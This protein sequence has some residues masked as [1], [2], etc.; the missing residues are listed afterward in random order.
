[1]AYIQQEGYGDYIAQHKRTLDILSE[2]QQIEIKHSSW[3]KRQRPKVFRRQAANKILEGG[4]VIDRFVP[5]HA[6][7]MLTVTLPGSTFKAFAAV[8]DWSG[9]IMNRV[10]QVIRRVPKDLPPVYWFFVLE[11]QKR[12]ALHMH[13]CIGW[14]VNA[15]MRRELGVA[16]KDKWF[17]CL[18]ELEKKAGVDCFQ[19]LGFAKSWRNSPE[20]WKWDYQQIKKSVASYFAKYC[21]K[22]SEINGEK[23]EAANKRK[24]YHSLSNKG[25]GAKRGIYY[26][27]RYWG[28]S[29]NI[30]TWIKRLTVSLSFDVAGDEEAEM[31]IQRIY[32]VCL[33]NQEIEDILEHEFEIVLPKSDICISS[34]IVTTILIPHEQYPAFW[35]KVV[36]DVFDKDICWDEKMKEFLG[37]ELFASMH[38]SEDEP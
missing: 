24:T 1:M 9:W 12:G 32:D 37:K 8:A 2:S 34:G 29:Q 11:H 21:Q 10:L 31:V 14:D 35:V 3:G 22:N 36:S 7:S 26:P 30:K 20:I 19:P 18:L 13:M 5:L 33:H 28:S 27:S 16:I 6:T 23:S 38:K 4:A 17:E 15:S 25:L